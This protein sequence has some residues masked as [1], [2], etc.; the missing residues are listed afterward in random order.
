MKRSSG[1][2]FAV[3]SWLVPGTA[4]ENARALKALHWPAGF[5]LA[6]MGLCCFE[7]DYSLHCPQ[8]N[9]PDPKDLPSGL[10]CHVHLPTDLPWASGKAAELC[11]RLLK[12]FSAV[13]R[14]V[15]HP[16]AGPDPLPLL[17]EFVAEWVEQG[18][19]PEDILLE[20]DRNTY[21]PDFLRVLDALP[22]N[23]CLDVAH[24]LTYG[25]DELLLQLAPE[26]VMLLHWSAPGPVFGKD[27]HQPL[28]RLTAEQLKTAR[29]T[30]DRF[31]HTLP[32]VEVFSLAGVQESLP[33]LLRLYGA[34]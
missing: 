18:L 9:Y 30:A 19:S 11:V 4:A 34:D 12:R 23:A 21:A 26:R 17:E 7:T 22:V 8:E 6:E 15:L 28:T 2:S 25:H 20:N 16:P 32:L 1:L 27:A 10:V 13:R 29:A 5:C 33:V 31:A 3:P 24:M 14:A